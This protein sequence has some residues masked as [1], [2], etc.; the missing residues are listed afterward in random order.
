[1]RAYDDDDLGVDDAMEVVEAYDR[2]FS[3][4]TESRNEA[5]A[6]NVAYRR[7][8]EAQPWRECTCPLCRDLGIEIAI[9]RGSNRNRRRGFHNLFQL[10]QALNVKRGP[11]AG[12]TDQLTVLA[13]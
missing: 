7:T 10:T 13:T 9:F 2:R 11:T 4:R 6:R 3:R 12:S 5:T 1:L 8:L